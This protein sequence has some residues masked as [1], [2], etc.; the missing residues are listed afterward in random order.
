MKDEIRRAA[1]SRPASS[2]A[3]APRTRF[4]K[5]EATG[6]VHA[7]AAS[8]GKPLSEWMSKCGW[9]LAKGSKASS[10]RE[11]GP[12]ALY[13]SV[14]EKCMPQYRLQLKLDL[15]RSDGSQ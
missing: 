12:P 8:D 5:N 10:I 2:C 6:I 1:S 14:C 4:V 9:R 7:L 3:D 13:K 11:C 15:G